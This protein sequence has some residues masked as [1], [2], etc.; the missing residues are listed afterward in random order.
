MT[1]APRRDRYVEL[2]FR[3]WSG[4]YDQPI[5]Q[6]PFYRRVHAAVLRAV[7]DTPAT[8]VVDLGCGTAQL[9]ADLAARYPNV[10]VVDLSDAASAPPRRRCS[11]PTSTPCPSATPPWI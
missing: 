6:K 10:A 4:F 7:G 5:L 11:A 1:E 8:T 3:V 9:T 2:L